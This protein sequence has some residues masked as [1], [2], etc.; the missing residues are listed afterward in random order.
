MGCANYLSLKDGWVSLLLLRLQKLNA[1]TI[2]ASYPF[3]HIDKYIDSSG[4]TKVFLTIDANFGFCRIEIDES[5]RDETAI[6]SHLAMYRLK[7]MPFGLKNAPAMLQIAM[8]V[9]LV[10]A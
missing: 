2:C 4:A 10:P 7:R 3:P 8:V 5:S 1:V 9:K 6:S